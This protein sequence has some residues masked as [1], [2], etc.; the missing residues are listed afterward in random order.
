MAPTDVSEAWLAE[1]E[2]R[3]ARFL[4]GATTAAPAAEAL[5]RV[6]ERLRR[7]EPPCTTSPDVTTRS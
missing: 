3:Y 4:A 6:R 7:R 2:R 5:Q 1:A